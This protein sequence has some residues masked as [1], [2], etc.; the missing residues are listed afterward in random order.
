MLKAIARNI[1]RFPKVKKT[2]KYLYYKI[3]GVCYGIF[4]NNIKVWNI[5]HD[6]GIEGDTFF[7]YY[8]T[9]P[10]NNNMI[11]FH[12]INKNGE[13]DVIIA[14]LFTSKFKVVASVSSFNLQQGAKLNWVDEN[15][16]I[17]NSY[18]SEKEVIIANLCRI[19]DFQELT[20]VLSRYSY[21]YSEVFEQGFLSLSYSK[22]TKEKSEYG[23]EHCK[24]KDESLY[25]KYIS[26]GSEKALTIVAEDELIPYRNS[27][28][29]NHVLNHILVSP[30]K[31]KFVFIERYTVDGTR[32]DRL[33]YKSSI[34]G[35]LKL[36]LNTGMVSHL[37]WQDDNLFGYFRDK[38]GRDGYHLL[39]LNSKTINCFDGLGDGHPVYINDS[40]IL[41]DT[42]PDFFRRQKLLLLDVRNEKSETILEHYIPSRF[43]N[44]TRCD[45]HPRFDSVNG[46]VYFDSIV[47][48]SRQLCRVDIREKLNHE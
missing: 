19:L 29:N 42:Y 23:Y 46:H 21:G 37:C 9:S 12:R 7:G 32:V 22:I 28:E 11:L 36:I 8:G 33:F 47:N 13:V 39:N 35:D 31:S 45:F 14:D 27:K 4:A 34:N 41:T 5:K 18:D 25:I 30:C 15:S 3:G 17:F 6:L 2:L 10:V 1:T 20:L 16:F 26:W 38:N 43:Q 40:L 48:G 44:K 24:M